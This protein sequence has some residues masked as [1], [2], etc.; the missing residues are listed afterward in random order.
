M[1]E[2]WDKMYYLPAKNSKIG[3]GVSKVQAKRLILKETTF[4]SYNEKSWEK[5]YIW[6]HIGP[7]WWKLAEVG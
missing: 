3:Q 5:G 4:M 1:D 6:P 7:F 2:I